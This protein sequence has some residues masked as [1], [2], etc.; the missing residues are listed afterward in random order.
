MRRRYAITAIH[1]AVA[2][3]NA[4]QSSQHIDK[5]S[6]HLNIAI[7]PIYHTALMISGPKR[8]YPI[9]IAKEGTSLA[10]PFPLHIPT[11]VPNDFSFF[12]FLFLYIHSFCRVHLLT[13]IIAIQVILVSYT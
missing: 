5:T 8:E 3:R 7:R 12:F 11:L 10:S 9:I 4:L 1:T 6:L 13:G 2:K